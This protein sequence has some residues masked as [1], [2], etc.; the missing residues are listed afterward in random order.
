VPPEVRAGGVIAAGWVA[1]F[2]GNYAR[3]ALAVQGSAPA[4]E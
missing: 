1:F 4:G 3:A 2:L